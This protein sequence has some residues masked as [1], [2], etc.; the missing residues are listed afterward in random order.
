[1]VDWPVVRSEKPV[2]TMLDGDDEEL[3]TEEVVKR[4]KYHMKDDI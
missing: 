1:M 2:S 3:K 4:I